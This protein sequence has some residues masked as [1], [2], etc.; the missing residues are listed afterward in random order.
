MMFHM[1]TRS[2]SHLYT[3]FYA[4]T[5]R[6]LARTGPSANMI[7]IPDFSSRVHQN[8]FFILKIPKSLWMTLQKSS[9]ELR[10]L[11]KGFAA[12]DLWITGGHWW[13]IN[14]GKWKMVRKWKLQHWIT[15]K[16]EPWLYFSKRWDLVPGLA[17]KKEENTPRDKC[18]KEC[19][20]FI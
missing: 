11:G 15:V 3:G 8:I 17:V 9:K 14:T 2:I 16:I 6:M 1:S 20:K 10:V 12:C 5:N 7:C 19:L 4:N 18:G 13:H